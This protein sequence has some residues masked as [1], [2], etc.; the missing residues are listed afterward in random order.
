M[1]QRLLDNRYFDKLLVNRLQAQAIR[2][3]N[4]QPPQ[5]S[6]LFSVLLENGTFERNKT[7]GTLIFDLNTENNDV[8]QFSDRPF[9]KTENISITEFV[10]LFTLGGS[11][12][13]EKDP[14]NM[15]LV[16]NEEQRTYEMKLS[17]Q[18]EN[19]AIFTL[20]LLPGETHDLTTVTG[21]MSLF[22]DNATSTP[23]FTKLE[24]FIFNIGNSSNSSNLL[25][26]QGIYTGIFMFLETIGVYNKIN[27]I[28][29]R[30]TCFTFANNKDSNNVHYFDS[31]G[32]LNNLYLFFPYNE[33]KLSVT[34]DKFSNWFKN[35]S[36]TRSQY[37]STSF[38]FDDLSITIEGEL[39]T[40]TE[41]NS[42]S[43]S[44]I[45]QLKDNNN[46][47]NYI[48]INQIGNKYGIGL[49]MNGVYKDVLFILNLT[50]NT[51]I[52]PYFV[53]YLLSG[54]VSNPV[55]KPEFNNNFN[56]GK[57]YRLEIF[58]I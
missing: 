26:I 33:T 31:S 35:N 39:Q 12:S 6:Y 36:I 28:E 20:L 1:S 41:D 13:F 32:D 38:M 43:N 56:I 4:V 37:L 34:N 16:H 51:S 50:N 47:N 53:E 11:N 22:V 3:D 46:S 44:N 5:I 27:G 2:S 57:T 19:Q 17:S 58:Y 54:P 52:G 25:N 30:F 21:R 15:V 9:R 49:Y 55:I 23:T 18:S 42:N 48:Y 8:I 10:N 45:Y 24:T 7:G 40:V 14:P 29:I